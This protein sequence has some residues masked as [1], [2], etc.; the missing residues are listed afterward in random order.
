M[1]VQKRNS[2][3]NENILNELK[4]VKLNKKLLNYLIDCGIDNKDEIE[5]FLHPTKES[6]LSPF[7]FEDMEKVCAKINNAVKNK[8]RILIFGDYDVD[9]IGSAAILVK[10]F[11]SINY[12]VDYFLPSRYDDGYGLSIESVD[13]VVSLFSPE[14][15][16][17][18]DCGITSKEEVEYIKQKGIDIIVTDHHDVIKESVPDCLIINAKHS[19]TY[20]FKGL[21]GAGVALKLV[22]ALAGYDECEKYFTICAI[23]TIADLMELRDENRFIVKKGLQEFYDKCPQGV[24]EL[25]K[26][27]GIEGEV[28]AKDI[29][30]KLSPKLNAAG[31]MGDATTGLK[32]YLSNNEQEIFDLTSSLLTLNSERQKLCSDIFI[33]S[34]SKE[35][36]NKKII[37]VYGDNWE[38]GMLGIVAA[39]FASK[40]SVPAIVLTY[41]EGVDAYVGSAR[42]VE[43]I[44]IHT[45]L[46]NVSSL[47]VTFGGH[48]M[49][50]GLTIKKE[51]IDE[52]TQRVT[53]QISEIEKDES[54]Y[55]DICLTED[56]VNFSLVNDMALLEPFGQGFEKP[57]FNLTFKECN[58]SL[59]KNHPENINILFENF[60]AVGFKMS[61]YYDVLKSALTKNVVCDIY[62][63]CFRGKTYVK[64]R[65]DYV[66]YACD[67]VLNEK[68]C[69]YNLS[70]N[71]SSVDERY[72]IEK[73]KVNSFSQNT[74]FIC[75]SF[76]DYLNF[77]CSDGYYFNC[78]SNCVIAPS[79]FKFEKEFDN[80]VF[81]S[82]PLSNLIVE[83]TQKANK[84]A[85]VYVV[86]NELSLPY[87]KRLS[88][89]RG[90][91]SYYYKLMLNGKVYFNRQLCYEDIKTNKTN[92]AQFIFCLLVFEELNLLKCEG[93]NFKLIATGQKGDLNNS[94]LYGYIKKLHEED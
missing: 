62:K 48:A 5:C 54:I 92:Y 85:N 8:K 40:Y 78:L 20:P 9:G 90:E 42:S 50:A 12:K 32:L 80:I 46:N 79:S 73:E 91:F 15:I 55:Y 43:G 3:N 26:A 63:E 21:C 81:L 1:R 14:L 47:L 57:V 71:I 37:I 34:D 94:V 28:T 66:D 13:K 4:D 77:K 56:E 7:L 45:I 38:C 88:C 27:C 41:D 65:I 69:E 36:V 86:N 58:V 6:F 23:S 31:R 67:A 53:E 2:K 93:E 18:V 10:Y 17:T 59:M 33:E 49:A 24:L 64:A 44:N 89:D 76:K 70:Y 83:E 30:F 16:I 84:N 87:L 72:L 19:K 68:E 11:E 22:C 39:R 74:L 29:G 25:S 82:K 60:S 75:N 51:N 52:F 61:M 35:F